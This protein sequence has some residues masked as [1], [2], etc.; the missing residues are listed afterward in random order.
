MPNILVKSILSS[1]GAIYRKHYILYR[2]TGMSV[3]PKNII[4]I[5]IVIESA[6]LIIRSILSTWA[7]NHKMI[8]QK[9][10]DY[11]KEDRERLINDMLTTMESKFNSISDEQIRH[12]GNTIFSNFR[13]T[14]NTLKEKKLADP[15]KTIDDL[16]KSW[17][18]LDRILHSGRAVFDKI[19]SLKEEDKEKTSPKGLSLVCLAGYSL[20]A[21]WHCCLCAY[22]SHKPAIFE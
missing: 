19:K 13:E 15:I 9:K 20:G 6:N 21:R 1:I 8:H 7:K 11:Y 3:E 14:I 12:Y 18:T 5:L 4:F 16:F 2:P 10:M 22:L 17:S